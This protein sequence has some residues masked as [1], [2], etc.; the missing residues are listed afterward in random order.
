MY[1]SIQKGKYTVLGSLN[2]VSDHVRYN[3]GKHLVLKV[4]YGDKAISD[5]INM[6]N[7]SIEEGK[8]YFHLSTLYFQSAAVFS[9]DNSTTPIHICDTWHYGYSLDSSAI[10]SDSISYEEIYGKELASD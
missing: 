10:N 6:L 2:S 9:S 3:D 5:A 4:R 7:K 8:K 1:I